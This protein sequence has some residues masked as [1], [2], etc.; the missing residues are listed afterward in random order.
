MRLPLLHMMSARRGKR[1]SAPAALDELAHRLRND[2]TASECE[3]AA[4]I[5]ARLARTGKKPDSTAWADAGLNPANR[6]PDTDRDIDIY[7][8]VESR[9]DAGATKAQA[10]ARVASQYQISESRAK[11]IFLK[12]HRA[13]EQAR[14]DMMD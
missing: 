4:A 3:E 7:R 8:A 13:E 2:P 9:L 6:P 1:G 12:Y 10:Y 11:A 5:L 14:Q